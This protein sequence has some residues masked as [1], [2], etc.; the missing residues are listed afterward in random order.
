MAANTTGSSI[1]AR[2]SMTPRTFDISNNQFT[3]E[4]PQWLVEH[5]A[6]CKEDITV[7]LDVRHHPFPQYQVCSSLD[8]TRRERKWNILHMLWPPEGHVDA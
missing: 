7:V 6:E 1:R 3:G 2:A 8:T 5:L 4:F